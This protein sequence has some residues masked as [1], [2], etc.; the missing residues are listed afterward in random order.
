MLYEGRKNCRHLFPIDK[1]IHGDDSADQDVDECKAY[2]TEKPGALP[3][4]ASSKQVAAT[5]LRG[6]F[7]NEKSD[8]DCRYRIKHR[9][10]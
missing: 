8:L 6:D 2:K 9:I 7:N 4:V 3:Y 5:K 10:N 1:A